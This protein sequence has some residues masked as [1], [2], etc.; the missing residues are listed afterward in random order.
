MYALTVFINIL[1]ALVTGWIII[2]LIDVAF[3]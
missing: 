2:M 3:G 1:L